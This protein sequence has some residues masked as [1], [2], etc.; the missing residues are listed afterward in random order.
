MPNVTLGEILFVLIQPDIDGIRF[1]C[2]S[3]ALLKFQ[4]LFT[5]HVAVIILRHAPVG[6]L[7]TGSIR[8]I[9]H[10]ASPS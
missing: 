4:V 9:R 6:A 3:A 5:D 10:P 1:Q 8:P 2:G 7:I